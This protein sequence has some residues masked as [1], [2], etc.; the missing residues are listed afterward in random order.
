MCDQRRQASVR[1]GVG[2]EVQGRAEG[3]AMRWLITD[4]EDQ[5]LQGLTADAQVL[6]MRG[7]RRSMDFETGIAEIGLALLRQKI[8]TIPDPKSRIQERRVE[9]ISNHYIRARIAELE[10]AEL[11]E[12]IPK[13]DRFGRPQYRC[14][15]APYAEVCPK[16]GPQENRKGRTASTTAGESADVVRL[17]DHWTARGTANEPQGHNRKRSGGPGYISTSDEVLVDDAAS[18]APSTPSS[19]APDCPHREI[20]QAY[21]DELPMCPQ[22]RPELWKGE[23]AAKLRARWR[24]DEKRQNVDWWRKLFRRIRQ[25]CPFLIGQSEPPPGRRPFQADLEWIVSPKN[26]VKILEGRYVDNG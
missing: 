19:T 4:E 22:V 25:T 23:R 26:F 24:E 18:Q 2:A 12:K 1:S 11:I 10:R 9:S 5:R 3:R 6:Y 15:A 17:E 13:E 21:H 7:F 16:S 14:L 8:E 20:I